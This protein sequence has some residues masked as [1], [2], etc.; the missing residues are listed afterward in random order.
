MHFFRILAKGSSNLGILVDV[1]FML[2]LQIW[3]VPSLLVIQC[4]MLPRAQLSLHSTVCKTY[5]GTELSLKSKTHHA[6]T[7]SKYCMNFWSKL[8]I[9]HLFSSP[10]FPGILAQMALFVG[11]MPCS[12]HRTTK[13]LISKYEAM[14]QNW[15]CSLC[16]V[17]HF[18]SYFKDLDIC[19]PSWSFF[20]LY[21]VYID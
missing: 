17:I 3:P 16:K 8:L 6:Q 2:P 14:C 5:P 1:S 9:C 12:C 7:Y 21:V 15:W 10:F 11:T 13:V 20:K 4:S 18:S 19:Y